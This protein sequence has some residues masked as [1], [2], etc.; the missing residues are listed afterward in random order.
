MFCY[1]SLSRCHHPTSS[2]PQVSPLICQST[3]RSPRSPGVVRIRTG[4]TPR[5]RCSG[6]PCWGKGQSTN[7]NTE[8]IWLGH[9]DRIDRTYSYIS[10]GL[11]LGFLML[12]TDSLKL[13]HRWHWKDEDLGQKDMTNI[14]KIH[15]QN[16]EQ[17]WQEILKWEQ[18]HKKWVTS[19]NNQHLRLW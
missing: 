9:R 18:F 2:L 13:F 6:M 8:E 12:C 7:Q 4:S 19:V 5:N 15:N 11:G 14:I 16:N 17:A 10:M 1:F 3:E